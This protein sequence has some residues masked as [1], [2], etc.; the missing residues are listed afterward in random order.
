MLRARL[1]D[2]TG[3]ARV[4]EVHRHRSPCPQVAA[5]PSCGLRAQGQQLQLQCPLQVALEASLPPLGNSR[6][7]AVTV[8]GQAAQFGAACSKG[9]ESGPSSA[10]LSGPTEGPFQSPNI[11][12]TW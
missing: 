1:R 2:L 8:V 10:R 9:S 6:Q 11:G 12:H 4:L 3:L 5:G 7:A